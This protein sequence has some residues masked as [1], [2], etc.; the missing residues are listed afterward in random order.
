M[1]T[2]SPTLAKIDSYRRQE[3]KL[4]L[5]QCTPEQKIKFKQMYSHLNLGLPTDQVI[6]EMLPDKIDRAIQQ[7]E[8]TIDKNKTRYP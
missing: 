1:K 5:D 2:T 3:L 4:L 6:D 8:A 7:C